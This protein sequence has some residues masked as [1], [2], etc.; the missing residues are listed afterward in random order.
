MSTPDDV[1]T[2]AADLRL[3]DQIEYWVRKTGRFEGVL[4]SVADLP[5]RLQGVVPE[6]LSQRGVALYVWIRE[7]GWLAL[8]T[9]EIVE[10]DEDVGECVSRCLHSEIDS[11]SIVLGEGEGQQPKFTAEHLDLNTKRG[12]LRLRGP[13][14]PPIYQVHNVLESLARFHAH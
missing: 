4:F 13:K 6:A 9:R 14:G 3:A 8:S 12:P 7:G 1:A 10:F 2:D 5:E 11:V